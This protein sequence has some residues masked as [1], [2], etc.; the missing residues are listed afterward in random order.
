MAP[1]K[2]SLYL[3]T[4]PTPTQSLTGLRTPRWLTY[5]PVTPIRKVLWTP[6]LFRP[7]VQAL[8][9]T[10]VLSIPGPITNVNRTLEPVVVDIGRPLSFR[11]PPL[12]GPTPYLLLTSLPTLPMV[13]REKTGPLVPLGL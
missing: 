6:E 4:L 9:G 2:C 1:W 5:V 12:S 13:Q 7:L 10:F 8:L 3:G 11:H